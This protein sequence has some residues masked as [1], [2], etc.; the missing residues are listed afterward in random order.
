[1]IIWALKQQAC[2]WDNT[3][4][5]EAARG[6]HLDI[7][8]WILVSN[9]GTDPDVPEQRAYGRTLDEIRRMS[10]GEKIPARNFPWEWETHWGCPFVQR[11]LGQSGM[12]YSEY[13]GETIAAEIVAEEDTVP[14]SYP[15]LTCKMAA[16]GGFDAVNAWCTHYGCSYTRA[17]ILFLLACVWMLN[18]LDADIG[19]NRCRQRIKAKRGLQRLLT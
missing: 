7:L 15:F 10:T 16:N 12:E 2:E 19:V 4:F 6:L 1:M 17:H 3:I 9:L 8:Q 18:N 11:I 13:G 14:C 5:Y